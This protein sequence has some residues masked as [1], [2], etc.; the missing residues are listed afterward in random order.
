MM[1]VSLLYRRIRMSKEKPFLY[2]KLRGWRVD[3]ERLV[4]SY[5]T[6]YGSAK[7]YIEHY[8]SREPLFFIVDPPK[9]LKEHY[10]W[11]CFC[12]RGKDTYLVHFGIKPKNP[13]SG[14][15]AIETVLM[16]ALKPKEV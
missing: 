8:T 11:V 12:H 1:M 4:G 15:L 14:I 9:Q 5:K 16:D 2:W 13:D 10:H 6:P 3:K 7:G